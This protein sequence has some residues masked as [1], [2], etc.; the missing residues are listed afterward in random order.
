MCFDSRYLSDFVAVGLDIP[1]WA[2][3]TWNKFLEIFQ[4]WHLKVITWGT[5]TPVVDPAVATDVVNA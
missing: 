1:D 3:E 5:K 2:M 4:I